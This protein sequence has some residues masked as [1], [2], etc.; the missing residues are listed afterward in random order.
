[1]CYR[2]ALGLILTL[3]GSSE[4]F[5]FH[6]INDDSDNRRKRIQSTLNTQQQ[7]AGNGG[8]EIP[9]ILNKYPCSWLWPVIDATALPWD[10]PCN[11]KVNFLR[12]CT[13]EHTQHNTDKRFPFLHTSFF[14]SFPL[15]KLRKEKKKQQQQKRLDFH[16]IQCFSS[17][18]IHL[19]INKRGF[20]NHGIQFFWREGV[21]FLDNWRFI[22]SLSILFLISTFS[23]LFFAFLCFSFFLFFFFFFL[24]HFT[25]SSICLKPTQISAQARHKNHETVDFPLN[26]A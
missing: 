16:S 1:M 25:S 6:Q 4:S 9:G 19:R 5:P 20:A 21:C 3:H 18:S 2:N 23:L 12:S 8:R 11:E 24:L 10:E 17:K 14:F 15:K 26:S 22:S 13:L 7:I